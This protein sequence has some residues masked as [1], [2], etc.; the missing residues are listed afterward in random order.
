MPWN[1]KDTMNLREEFVLLARQ[2]GANRRALCQRFGISP[3]TAY[4]WLARY[5]QHGREG[6]LDRTTRPKVSPRQTP[7]NVEHTVLDLRLKHPCWGGRKLS[8]RLQDL[9]HP[10]VAPSTITSILHRHGLI[11]PQA[12]EAATPWQRFEHAAPNDLWQMDFKGYVHTSESICH[13]LTVLDDHSR[14]SL[15]IRACSEQ[16]Y[17]TVQAHLADIFARYGLPVR[18]NTDNGSP[19]G[20]SREPGQL[21]E[22]AIWLI[23][24]GIHISFSRPYHP[25]T[26]GKEERF[27]R[28]L[29]AEVLQGRGFHSLVQAQHAFDH[30]RD[31]YNNQ[32][33]HEALHMATPSTRYR[34]SPRAY[35]EQL[36]DI[37]Y[38]P[39]D[40][41]VIVKWGGEIK[42]QGQRFK[43]SNPLRGYPVAIR[44]EGKT[45][46]LF[47]VFF[48]HHKLMQI[49]LRA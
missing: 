2:D 38:S 21:T 23:R 30:W 42:V 14:F 16:R 34:I 25:Q 36:P 26:N 20:S 18:I 37:E 46:G 3:Q 41:V 32:R 6:L 24:L 29:K 15:G 19:W 44:P 5:E 8:R 9:G 11:N 12:S 13:P 48:I 45:D 49:D 33:P 22:L 10:H 31:V 27:H 35:P 4:K 43:L 40:R 47:D 39:D 28:S 1:V 7:P 17:R